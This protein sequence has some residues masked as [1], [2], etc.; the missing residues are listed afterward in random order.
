MYLFYNLNYTIPL[1]EIQYFFINFLSLLFM[2]PLACS[3]V[4]S[5]VLWFFFLFS[6]TRSCKLG[7]WANPM[8]PGLRI[9]FPRMDIDFFLLGAWKGVFALV[10]GLLL[11][12]VT[13]A[14]TNKVKNQ[15]QKASFPLVPSALSFI[16]F[17]EPN[18][19]L[20]P[21]DPCECCSMFQICA[22]H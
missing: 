21:Q 4:S 16:Q 9:H 14:V 17:C 11:A 10:V 3:I 8:R 12:I 6:I 15:D 19:L 18:M 5:W 22:V 13:T 20:L 2:L 1:F 7:F